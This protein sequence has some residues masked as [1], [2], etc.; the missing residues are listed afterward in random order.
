LTLGDPAKNFFE[1]AD[2]VLAAGALTLEL[3]I[4]SSQPKEGA[5]LRAS[6]ERALRAGVNGQIAIE[7]L[8][9]I[10]RRHAG[11]PLVAVIQ[12]PAAEKNG[13]LELLLDAIAAAGA[14][15]VLPVGVSVWQY[16][17][18]AA[19]VH[20]RRLETVLPCPPSASLK[21]RQIVYRF[22]SG[23][24]YVP[25]GRVTG[26]AKE[27]GNFDEFCRQ[28]S[29]ETRTPMIV[30]VGVRSAADVTEICNTP[31]KAAAVGT[32]LVEHIARGGRADEFIRGLQ[33]LGAQEKAR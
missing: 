33:P 11:L 24:L 26:S 4:P 16:P 22:C 29:S 25:R 19:Q 20:Q 28:V 23:C 32:A 12:W 31:A 6:H 10:A 18:L 3:G 9:G 7:L 21:L 27:F 1:V 2:A 17:T 15:A 13:E 5:V 14:A 8:G 30:G